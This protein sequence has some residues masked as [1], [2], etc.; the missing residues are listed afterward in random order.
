MHLLAAFTPACC[1]SDVDP[2]QLSA[3]MFVLSRAHS[4]PYADGRGRLPAVR[5]LDRECSLP[6]FLSSVLLTVRSGFY[7]RALSV[8]AVLVGCCLHLRAAAMLL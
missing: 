1:W 8:R 3:H 7:A 6:A 4:D 2:D 5:S